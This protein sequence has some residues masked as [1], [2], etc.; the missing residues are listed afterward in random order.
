LNLKLLSLGLNRIQNIEALAGLAQL[1][2][3]ILQFNEIKDIQ[4]LVEN[5]GLGSGD[6]VS[7]RHN[8]LDLKEGSPHLE[9][10]NKLKDRGVEVS[11]E[12]QN[13]P[14]AKPAER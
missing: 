11:Y 2:W 4:P 1:E 13:D 9:A 14:P 3:L 8:N 7:I 10:I 5:E 6:W 12:P